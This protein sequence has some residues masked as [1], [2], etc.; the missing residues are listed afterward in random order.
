MIIL[1]D[2]DILIE[3]SR[4]RNPAILSAWDSLSESEITLLY[5]PVNTAELWA[6]ARPSE[7]EST[8]KL[9]LSLDCV[10]IDH[11]IG[12]LAGKFMRIFSKSHSLKLGDALI[13]ATAVQKQANLWTRNRN[14][15]PMQEVSFYQ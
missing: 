3:I 13:A 7:T 2:S 11:S 6:G 1:L 14:H 5:S 4:G 9:L 15:Y 8:E 12:E 10:G